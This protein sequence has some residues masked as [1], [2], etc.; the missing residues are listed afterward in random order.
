MKRF[1][2]MPNRTKENHETVVRRIV[3]Y[4]EARGALCQVAEKRPDG[5]TVPGTI[6]RDAQV[7]IVLG[8]DGTMTMAARELDGYNIPIL[9][10]NM[11]NLGYIAEVELDQLEESLQKLLDDE[12]YMEIRTAVQASI[13]GGPPK[14]AVN[15]IVVN[16]QNEL[17]VVDF[18]V[19]VNGELLNV[20]SGDG[21]IL[22]TPTGS[23]GYNLS[24]GGPIME[25]S[26]DMFV[27]TPICPHDLS[28]RSIVLSAED[29]IEVV[30]GQPR[31]RKAEQAAVSFDARDQMALVTG[32][33]V[34]I[35]RHSEAVVFIKLNKDGFMKVMRRKMKGNT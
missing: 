7:A 32:D 30:I 18:Y 2:L 27:V 12:Y 33:V 5:S 15:D 10:I 20:Y 23:T 8:G 16:R 9:G 22:S 28:A 6:P 24:A 29:V 13:N 26:A 34:R 25:P 14:M 21:V 19:Y 3:S 1:F 31:H 35:R 17:R 4:L 11:G